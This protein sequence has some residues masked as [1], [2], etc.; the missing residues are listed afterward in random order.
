MKTVLY[1][2]ANLHKPAVSQSL[3]NRKLALEKAGFHVELYSIEIQSLYTFFMVYRKLRNSDIILIR[4]DQTCIT[5]KYTLVKLL[6]PKV[7]CIWEIHGY[8]KDNLLNK[9]KP[10]RI[11]LTKTSLIRF[12]LS[13]FVLK[14]IFASPEQQNVSQKYLRN[15]QSI[16]ISNFIVPRHYPGCSRLTT[17]NIQRLLIPK[18][19][20]IVF[21]GGSTDSPWS[22]LSSIEETAKRVYHLDKHIHFIIVGSLYWCGVAWNRNIS[23]VSALPYKY[24]L[25]L[26]SHSHVCLALYHNNNY[27]KFSFSPQNIFD[28]MLEKKAIIASGL[29]PIRKMIE[30]GKNGLIVPNNPDV[31]AQKILYLKKNPTIRRDL[32]IEAYKSLQQLFSFKKAVLAYRKSLCGTST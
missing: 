21:W 23:L 11:W 22:A 32:G 29:H 31:I 13:N 4:L 17:S 16:V 18:K 20:F 9:N 12:V 8:P 27:K 15:R 28:Y 7:F 10:S 5:D 6:F 25:Y 1:I 19:R 2:S 30:D 14:Y 26:I 24:Y 3:K